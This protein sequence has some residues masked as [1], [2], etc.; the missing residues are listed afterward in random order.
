MALV[1]FHKRIDTDIVK[2]EAIAKHGFSITTMNLP[3]LK[4]AIEKVLS[5]PALCHHSVCL[6]TLLH[7][8]MPLV[9]RVSFSYVL[10]IPDTETVLGD[11]VYRIHVLFCYR[12]FPYYCQIRSG[13]FCGLQLTTGWAPAHHWK[14]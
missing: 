13:V 4:T 11:P 14:V 6:F 2:I 1:V 9:V 10:D 7:F 12:T 3:C 5:H 8:V